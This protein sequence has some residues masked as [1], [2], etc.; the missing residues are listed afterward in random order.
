MFGQS[1]ETGSHYGFPYEGPWI[2]FE[3]SYQEFASRLSQVRM[4][5]QRQFAI[6]AESIRKVMLENAD[7]DKAMILI[8]EEI[9]NAVSR[10]PL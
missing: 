8:Q 5:S 6:E 9:G 4:T 1:P 7:S 2:V 3:P 10:R